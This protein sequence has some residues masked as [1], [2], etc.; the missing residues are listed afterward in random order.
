M[1]KILI[2]FAGL[3]FIVQLN[4]QKTFNI[5]SF[6]VK[7]IDVRLGY[8]TDMVNGLDYS[9]FVNQM[10][11]EHQGLFSSA[12]FNPTTLYGGICENPSLELGLT[13]IHDNL[14]NFEW[15]NSLAYK[16]DRVDAV[17]YYSNDFF[18]SRYVNFD[19]RHDEYTLESSLV[20]KL[21]IFSFFNLYG[22]I[23][24]NIGLV[25]QS[26]TCVFASLDFNVDGLGYQNIEEVNQTVMADNYPFY[27]DCYETG[28]QLN[29][30]VFLQAGAGL[31]FFNKIEV[32]MDFKYGHGYRADFKNDV[33]GTN[34]I[35]SN[36]TLRYIL[37]DRA[38]T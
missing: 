32:G 29:Q 5:G 28:A 27:G 36:L 21:P 35:S 15:R 34:I 3:L 11:I 25:P 22:G 37:N 14:P 24:T 31:K 10:P 18:D 20:Y 4:A 30:R 17:T 8:E 23:G 19:S 2:V 7:K 6:T 1:K 33:I 13:L 26:E 38:K 9:Y 12:D 16:Q